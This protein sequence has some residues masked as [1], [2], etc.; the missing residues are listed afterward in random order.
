MK[1]LIV[2]FVSLLTLTVCNAGVE[3]VFNPDGKWVSTIPMTKI[4]PDLVDCSYTFTGDSLYIDVYPSG[5]GLAAMK[6]QNLKNLKNGFACEA[7]DTMYD[8][9]TGKVLKR[10]TYRLEFIRH[11]NTYSVY[12]DGTLVDIIRRNP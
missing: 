10:K 5:C 9:Y 1:R 12:R 3:L 11:K 2:L 7:I 4:A 8:I 6:I